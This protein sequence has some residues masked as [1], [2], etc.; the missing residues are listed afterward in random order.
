MMAKFMTSELVEWDRHQWLA[1]VKW[2]AQQG[3][4][5]PPSFQGAFDLQD[6]WREAHRTKDPKGVEFSPEQWVNELFSQG[7]IASIPGFPNF[8]GAR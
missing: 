7:M 4:E 5:F 2:A 6:A 3:L 8:R 1:V